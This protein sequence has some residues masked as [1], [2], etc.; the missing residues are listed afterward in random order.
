MLRRGRFPVRSLLKLP[1]FSLETSTWSMLGCFLFLANRAVLWSKNH[2]ARLNFPHQHDCSRVTA[3]FSK[4]LPATLAT[5][6]TRTNDL[7]PFE[8]HNGSST[9]VRAWWLWFHHRPPFFEA[10]MKPKKSVKT[11]EMSNLELTESPEKVA[12]NPRLWVP[13]FQWHSK[14]WTNHFFPSPRRIWFGLNPSCHIST[15]LTLWNLQTT[16]V[17]SRSVAR[18]IPPREPNNFSKF[19]SLKFQNGCVFAWIGHGTVDSVV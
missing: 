17:I 13:S 1:C 14:D 15:F 19:F 16:G 12:T 9:Q 18:S 7:W 3:Q 5:S 10:Q 6:P 4:E 11:C 2:C 8:W